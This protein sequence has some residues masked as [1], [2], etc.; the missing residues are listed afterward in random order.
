MTKIIHTADIHLGSSMQARLPQSK[1]DERK[2]ELRQAFNKMLDYAKKAGVKIILLSGDVFDSDR[3]SKKDKEFFYSAIKSNPD[4]DFLY[5]RGNHDRAESYTESDIANLKTF[6]SEWSYYRYG[7]ICIAGAEMTDDNA[8]ILYRS[9][10]LGAADINIVMLHGQVGDYRDS[11]ICIPRLKGKNIDYLALGH[12]H[13]YDKFPLDDRGVCV[14]SGC[15][16]GRGFDEAGQ[17]GFVCLQIDDRISDEFVINSIRT[18]NRLQVDLSD[19]SD[20]YSACRKAEEAVKGLGRD[21]VRMELTGE[22]DFDAEGLAA[23]IEK[24]LEN[25]CYFLS[26]KD[27]TLRRIDIE[28]LRGDIS[29]RGEFIRR[30]LSNTGYDEAYRSK[31]ISLGLRA[32]N[33]RELDI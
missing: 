28:R 13:S 12:I 24:A 23:E 11:D 8:D 29:L 18:V 31:I 25:E 26:A 21:I 7:R 27:M 22:I 17:K 16:E 10:Q 32:L 20:L 2:T 5:L 19:T 14:Y 15:L 9:L 6:S 1:A 4:I 3:P 33:G 30:V